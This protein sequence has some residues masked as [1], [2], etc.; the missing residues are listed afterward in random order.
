[1]KVREITID[2]FGVW[3]GLA[4]ADLDD[5]LNVFYGPNEAGKTTLLQ[6][7]RA[8]LY[9]FSTERRKRYL[10]PVHGGRSGGR[11]QLATPDG[12]F[13]VD[14]HAAD[15]AATER[16][17]ILSG[18]EPLRDDRLLVQMLGGVDEIVY[19][20]VFAIGL[21]EIQEL[22]SLSDT[23]AAQWLYKL[24]VGTDRVSLVDVISELNK[25][26]GRLLADGEEASTIPQLLHDRDEL[27]R[28]ASA[29]T[30]VRQFLDLGRKRRELAAQIESWE[31][32]AGEAERAARLVEVAAAIFD[33]WHARAALEKELA[34]AGK[35]PRVEQQTLADFTSLEQSLARAKARHK[36]LSRLLARTRND[37]DRLGLDTAVSQRA[38]RI[39][40]LLEQEQWITAL[41]AERV[42]LADKVAALETRR[43]ESC[44][45][46]GL[47]S[48]GRRGHGRRGRQGVAAAQGAG[49]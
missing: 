46:V 21:R 38:A 47:R 8:M 34:A 16:V 25:A 10:P 3:T 29:H 1:M 39:E 48:G 40:S 35:E 2:G 24:A 6:F 37:I 44:R 32:E 7:V 11:L 20:N 49:R 27:R 13:T 31:S 26:R 19:R 4:L 33:K 28:Q 14:R 45:A 43:G 36:K 15:A 18:E 41:D 23:E 9:G 42:A 22:G 17:E 30:A 5:H 12:T